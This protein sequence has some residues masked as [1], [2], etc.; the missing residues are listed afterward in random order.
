MD[1][2]FKP[3]PHKGGH[4]NNSSQRIGIHFHLKNYQSEAGTTIHSIMLI[5]LSFE[6]ANEEIFTVQ[7]GPAS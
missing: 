3:C 6:F 1:D 5:V 4:T 7:S 2:I